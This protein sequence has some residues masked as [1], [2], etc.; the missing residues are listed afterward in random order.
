ME[1][2]H[3]IEIWDT[4]KEYISD[5]N[6]DMAANQYVDYLI[7]RDVELSVLENVMGF[8]THLDDAIKT[9]LDEHKEWDEEEDSEDYWDEEEDY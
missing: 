6:K 4:F 3:I 2:S 1:E 5:K 8:D 7:G 9:V